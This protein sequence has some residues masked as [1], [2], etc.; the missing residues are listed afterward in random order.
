MY[1]TNDIR[2]R[3]KGEARRGDWQTVADK[4]RKARKTVYDI[5]AGRRNNDAVLAAFEQLLDE[6]A[7]L[8]HGAAAPADEAG[9]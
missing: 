7:E 5:V 8:L 2:Q 1:N 3:I 6:R 4:T 9:E